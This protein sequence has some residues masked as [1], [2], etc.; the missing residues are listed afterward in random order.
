MFETRYVITLDRL[1]RYCPGWFAERIDTIVKEQ[2]AEWKDLG[3]G[4]YTKVADCI[5]KT[6]GD[7]ATAATERYL[8]LPIDT[9]NFDAAFK[10]SMLEA[11]TAVV[12]LDEA[13]DG[14]AFHSDNWQALN[15]LQEKWRDSV[16]CIYI[17]PPYNT[18][19]SGIPYK[20]G[21]RHAS[22]AALMHNRIDQLHRLLPADGAIFVSIDK[23]E[24]TTLEHM[25]N[26]VFGAD[27]RVEELIWAMNTNN[28]QA[29]NYST[30]HEYVQVYARHRPTVEQDRAMF[31]EPKP[32]FEEVMALVAELHPNYPR[33]ADIEAAIRALYEQH[34]LDY[35]S[36]IEAQGLDLEEEK[37]NDPWRGLYNYSRAEYRDAD[38]KLVAETEAKEKSANI[39]VWREDNIAMPATKQ[40]TSTS[41]P[42]HRNWRFYNPP[43]PVTG[44]PCPHPKSGWK[45]AYD[46]DEDSPDKRSFTALARDHRIAFGEDEKK[47]PQI[48]RMLH[49]V[50]TNV[51][52]SVFRDYSDG[53]KQTSAMFGKSGVF[54]APKHS[55]FV[56]RFILQG[57]K[58]DSMVLDCF[59]GS[60]STAHAVINV[61]RLERSKRKFV[62]VE[63]N[64]YFETIIIPRLKKAFA[65]TAWSAGKAKAMDG[66]GGFMR[67]QHL[68]QYE[69]ALEN[70]DI[71]V[72]AGDTG[73]LLFH[74]P[75]FAM[76][77]RLDATTR[78]LYC[79][80]E[81]FSSPFGYQL[82]RST[83]GGA[84]Q[85]CEVDLL[86][87]IPYLLGLE[88]IRLYRDDQGAVLLGRNRRKQSVAVFFRNCAAPDS[89][90]WVQAKLAKHPADHIYTND[91]ASLCFEGCDQFE[92]IETIFAQQFGRL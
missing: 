23:T 62:T 77:Y 39:W 2:R 92:A 45:Y 44:Q 18:N 51:G 12:G 69:D 6:E 48:K 57:S 83:G 19:S 50:E 54:L 66:P 73:E 59:G 65:A 49:E 75:A 5:H 89:A 35:R 88:V 42:T 29:P 78:S 76:R 31:R 81:R 38:G 61:N 53:E 28:S 4:D 72:L 84:A 1:E 13:L 11:V 68:E 46:D 47:I 70:L 87:S 80:V 40:A 90:E 74:D 20:N 52:K 14:T 7:L 17:D 25:L 34:K 91:S 67:V 56:S 58:P 63:V 21:Y 30:N 43:H 9:R 71:E 37:D 85:P 33:I 79:G 82:K 22:F 16:K 60:G 86:E 41:D 55:D 36:N 15:T 64:R 10:W 3:L 8:P 24:R 27:N 26:A 32:G